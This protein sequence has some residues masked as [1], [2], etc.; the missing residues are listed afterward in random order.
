M[1]EAAALGK[2]KSNAAAGAGRPA[3]ACGDPPLATVRS[4]ATN[5][6]AVLSPLRGRTGAAAAA[7]ALHFAGRE[8]RALRA[9]A[10]PRGNKKA[11]SAA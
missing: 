7:H 1:A 3:K 11:H 10:R 8:P 5:A 6:Q 4:A 2:G 9:S